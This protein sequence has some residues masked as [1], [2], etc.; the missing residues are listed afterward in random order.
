MFVVIVKE[1]G[2]LRVRYVMVIGEEM[3]ICQMGKSVICARGVRWYGAR[4]VTEQG[5]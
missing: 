2:M 5:K 3:A 1:A 4:Y